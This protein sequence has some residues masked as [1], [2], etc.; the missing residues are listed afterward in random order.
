MK[1]FLITFLVLVAVTQFCASSNLIPPSSDINERLLLS[2]GGNVQNG[3]DII[4]ENPESFNVMLAENE[5]IFE[6]CS[7]GCNA[8]FLV[9]Y[10][11]DPVGQN[12]LKECNSNCGF[13][14]SARGDKITFMKAFASKTGISKVKECDIIKIAHKR[15]PFRGADIPSCSPKIENGMVKLDI[16]N[17]SSECPVIIKNAMIVPETT[18]FL[19]TTLSIS[20]QHGDK[21]VNGSIGKETATS[22][23]G[24]FFENYWWIFLILGLLIIIIITIVL[25]VYCCRRIRT[26]KK[27]TAPLPPRRLQGSKSPIVLQPSTETTHDQKRQ[28][29]T[30]LMQPSSILSH[31]SLLL[32]KKE[33]K[34]EETDLTSM[35]P[36]A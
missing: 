19:P 29:P 23:T 25:I 6:V 26:T 28:I 13:Y 33:I 9:C 8:D 35:K 2:D 27:Q 36:T 15:T 24:G 1:L 32:S 22:E 10:E 34:S 4:M 12:V 31:K 14:V 7:S 20:G 18:T 21:N 30:S 3:S 11:A 16:Q 17:A 5:L